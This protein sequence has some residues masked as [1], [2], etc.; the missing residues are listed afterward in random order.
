MRTQ[1]TTQ[2]F[3]IC[4]PMQKDVIILALYH[5]GKYGFP[6]AKL[7]QNQSHIDAITQEINERLNLEIIK[8]EYEEHGLEFLEIHS[9]PDQQRNIIESNGNHYAVYLVETIGISENR[10]EKY[11]GIIP[12]HIKQITQHGSLRRPFLEQTIQNAS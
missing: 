6:Y 9:W 7:K 10:G 5:S 8:T 3:I 4:M 12:R 2:E 11:K 1:T